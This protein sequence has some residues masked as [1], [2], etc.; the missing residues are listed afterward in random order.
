MKLLRNWTGLVLNISSFVTVQC[1][2]EK[3]EPGRSQGKTGESSGLIQQSVMMISRWWRSR[4]SCC[5]VLSGVIH[6]F[7]LCL[8]GC[9]YSQ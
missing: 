7:D 3:A 6:R 9:I 1:C 5:V 8:F 2:K 4:V